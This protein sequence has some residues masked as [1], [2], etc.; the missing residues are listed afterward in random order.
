MFEFFIFWAIKMHIV[1]TRLLDRVVK[2]PS[3][4]RVVIPKSR[5]RVPSGTLQ[6]LTWGEGAGG[7]C[8]TYRQIRYAVSIG[9]SLEDVIIS[10]F[11]HRYVK[12]KV[13]TE[14]CTESFVAK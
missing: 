12:V 5:S 3:R 2:F 13:K 7:V 14:I 8:C 4:V 10:R 1:P 9:I 6:G 11:Q